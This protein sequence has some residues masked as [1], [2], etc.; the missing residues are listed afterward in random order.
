M[1]RWRN[2]EKMN[3]I[4]KINGEIKQ[5]RRFM[6]SEY[7]FTNTYFRDGYITALEKVKELIKG[8]DQKELF[9]GKK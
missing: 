5:A 9:E 1:Y 4:D 3:I 6:T 8:R 2:R 7:Q